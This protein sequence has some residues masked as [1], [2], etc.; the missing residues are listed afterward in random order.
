[1]PYYRSNNVFLCIKWREIYYVVKLNKKPKALIKNLKGS[2][3]IMI[4]EKEFSLGFSKSKI[5]CCN[6]FLQK[7]RY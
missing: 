5:I 4:D 6:S 2:V 7:F 1:M 3:C